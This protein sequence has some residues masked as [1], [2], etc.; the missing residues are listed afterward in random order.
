MLVNQ[1]RIGVSYVVQIRWIT[2]VFW[3]M[4]FK[5][6]RFNDFTQALT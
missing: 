2:T 5:I 4:L 3:G 1:Q 6:L